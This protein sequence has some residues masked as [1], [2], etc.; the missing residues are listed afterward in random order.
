[1]TLHMHPVVLYEVRMDMGTPLGQPNVCLTKILI[2]LVVQS[3][4]SYF[5]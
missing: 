1:M 4:K 5:S 2:E 3:S